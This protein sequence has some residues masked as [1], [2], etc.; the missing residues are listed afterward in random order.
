MIAQLIAPVAA[1]AFGTSG[2]AAQDVAA[3]AWLSGDWEE[4]R[5]EG[6]HVTTW[7][8][9]HW[10]RPRGG[11]MLG[12]NLSGRRTSN[13][14]S[15]DVSDTARGF[16]F[17]RIARGSDGAIS[18]HASPGGAPAVAFRLV[19]SGKAEAVFENSANDYPQRVSYRRQGDSLI[20]TISLI[21]GSK[22]MSWTFRR[23]R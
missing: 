4:V 19:R 22:P 20:G 2:A 23:R 10:S 13:S 6:P 3:L 15:R 14:S 17:M 7:T 8:V 1:L 21:D 9:E 11:V 5:S 18:F 16:E 12:T